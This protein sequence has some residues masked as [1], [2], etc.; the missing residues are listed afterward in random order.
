MS[1]HISSA[2]VASLLRAFQEKNAIDIKI[3]NTL[4]DGQSGAYVACVDCTGTLEDGAEI[5]GQFIL[6]IDEID[7]K[8]RTEAKAYVAAEH[9]RHF[10]N[11]LPEMKASFHHEGHFLL[12]VSAAGNSL[13]ESRPLLENEEYFAECYSLLNTHLRQY[14]PQSSLVSFTDELNA[15]L[16]MCL[17]TDR[18]KNNLKI[19]LPNQFEAQSWT[20]KAEVLPNP[21]QVPPDDK[22]FRPFRGSMHGDCHQGNIF[23]KSNRNGM[24]TDLYLID[25]AFYQEEGPMFF[26]QA[27][28]ELNL[29]LNQYRE[30]GN[31]KWL[32]LIEALT[33]LSPEIE[34]TRF[35]TNWV[36]SISFGRKSLTD[37]LYKKHPDRRDDILNQFYASFVAAG[38]FVF[39]RTLK[40]NSDHDSHWKALLWSSL[41]LRAYLE[42]NK[43]WPPNEERPVVAYQENITSCEYDMLWKSVGGFDREGFNVLIITQDFLSLEATVQETILSIPWA[44]IFDF[45]SATSSYE[46]AQRRIIRR[47]FAGQDKPP[48]PIVARQGTIWFH[49]NGYDA[50]SGLSSA[51]EGR[52]WGRIY[53]KSVEAF[54]EKMAEQADGKDVRVLLYTK[55]SYADE[56]VEITRMFDREWQLASFQ[57]V[58]CDSLALQ[59]RCH[60]EHVFS[61]DIA[62]LATL[63]RELHE[64]PLMPQSALIPVRQGESLELIPLPS[65]TLKDW[66]RFFTV[67]H[68]GLRNVIPPERPLGK[69][70]L[71]GMTIEWAE[72]DQNFAVERIKF[73]ELVNKIDDRLKASSNHTV[74][75]YHEPSAGGTT[76]SRQIAWHFKE[77]YPTV[78]LE[79]ASSETAEQIASLFQ[80]TGLPVLVVLDAATVSESERENLLRQLRQT[81]TRNVFLWVCRSY[82]SEVQE[83]ILPSLLDKE[84]EIP[85]FLDIYSRECGAEDRRINLRQLVNYA[86]YEKQRSPFFFGLTAFEREYMGLDKAVC[87]LWELFAPCLDSLAF[88]ALITKF[89]SHP[90]P[91]KEFRMLFK[92]L[93]KELPLPDLGKTPLIA[94]DNKTFIK[95]PHSLIADTILER[96]FGNEPTQR[97]YQA[98]A[99][100]FVKALE[101][102]ELTSAGSLDRLL[103]HLFTN[104]D[105]L[106]A[107]ESDIEF[108]TGRLGKKR[109]SQLITAISIDSPEPAR[110][111]FREVV[112]IWP[113]APHYAIHYARLLLYRSPEK[114]DEAIS[115]IT[116]ALATVSGENDPYVH[117]MLGMCYRFKMN[118]LFN[119]AKNNFSYER[120]KNV[121]FDYF[122]KAVEKF[123]LSS[124]ISQNDRV[125][126]VSTIQ[127]CHEF[128]HNSMKCLSL[129]EINALP[130]DGLYTRA[131]ECAELAIVHLRKQSDLNRIEVRVLEQFDL[132]YAAGTKRYID[133]L[134]KLSSS[135]IH[136]VRQL[137][138][139]IHATHERAWHKISQNDLHIMK[140]RLDSC[141][142]RDNVTEIDFHRWVNISRYCQDF[143]LLQMLNRLS[144]WMDKVSKSIE[145]LYYMYVFQFIQMMNTPPE[146]AKPF[147]DQMKKSLSV[148]NKTNMTQGRDQFS[149]E[150]LCK[151]V[152]GT[153]FLKPW[154]EISPSLRTNILKNKF[155]DAEMVAEGLCRVIG[156]LVGYE[157]QKAWIDVKDRFKARIIPHSLSRDNN[158]ELISAYISFS[159]DE[160]RGWDPILEKKTSVLR[161]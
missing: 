70:F 132:L 97:D 51:P 68:G 34:S 64:A 108:A 102:I 23:V 117:H 67:V 26:D 144:A 138:S 130:E 137:C 100:Q 118:E 40:Q 71:K 84:K 136:Y 61:A 109:F 21:I 30:A 43:N 87:G 161:V 72:L 133:K 106:S 13:M 35:G 66:N 153:Y 154:L 160:I 47:V 48:D 41:F 80:F 20:Y 119:H 131:L 76:L 3:K 90:I 127:S 152:D 57:F 45:H 58:F 103:Q 4:T 111:L 6:K 101:Q 18:L 121:I 74:N 12:L 37:Y 75:L 104:R 25:L 52:Q 128:L 44:L 49:V 15:I 65:K 53:H 92:Y 5:D 159:Y 93:S 146:S 115:V 151:T 81:N 140:N 38:L 134:K 63:Y 129:R 99:L 62:N 10:P 141:L 55:Y 96:Y 123:S 8:R 120:H 7:E 145:P 114:I 85:V 105:V 139:Y 148:C 147:A 46:S 126:N 31:T 157:R 11:I 143:D 149:R 39:N 95:I 29:L 142:H 32:K 24:P 86:A 155:S 89:T 98:L 50:I 124:S 112:K 69:A 60:S 14:V 122:Q 78:I 113:A 125:S 36:K 28:L 9:L 54:I 158:G 107:L 135:D 56:M 22:T 150:W 42:L 83:D 79:Q 59:Q 19:L 27:Y 156:I 91:F 77:Q 82:S 1:K 94:T 17:N 110:E 2:D 116:A 33:S 88:L 73:N 16:A